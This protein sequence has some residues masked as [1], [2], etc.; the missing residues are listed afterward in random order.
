MDGG[1]FVQI[2]FCYCENPVNLKISWSNLNPGRRFVGCKS[3]GSSSTCRFFSW[4]DP[5]MNDRAR[6]VLVG[7]LKKVK[8]VESQRKNERIV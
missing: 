7:L 6:V 5:P 3:Y 2:P 4:Y 8:V 1:Q